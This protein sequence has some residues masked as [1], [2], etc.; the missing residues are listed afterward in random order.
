MASP[1]RNAGV[2]ASQADGYRLWLAGRGYTA[3]TVRNMLKDFGQ[4]G[5]WLSRQGLD[6]CDLSEAALEDFLSDRR[7]AG[8]RRLPGPRGMLPLLTFL[9]EAGASPVSQAVLSPLE[10]LLVR[11]RSWM[12]RERGLSP[13]TIL[14]YENIARR[15]LAE[16]AVV[17]DVFAPQGLTGADLNAFLLRECARVS[18][19]SAKGRVAELRSLMRFLHLDGV[20]PTRLGAAVP[21]VGGWRFAT[22]PPRIAADGVQRLLECCPPK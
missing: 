22:V 14:R 10:A 13:A 12:T 8:R 5:L 18:G 7:E 4:V 2:L 21:P 19:G 3:Q 1:R 6:A 16:Q 15:F 20:T 17:G 9:R 11:Y